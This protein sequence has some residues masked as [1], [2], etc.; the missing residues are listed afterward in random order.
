MYAISNL[1]DPSVPTVDIPASSLEAAEIEGAR[2]FGVRQEHVFA[3]RTPPGGSLPP[4]P[5]FASKR[6]FPGPSMNLSL[7]KRPT[8]R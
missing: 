4:D 1:L 3:R 2:R 8:S 5:R 6:V 7:D